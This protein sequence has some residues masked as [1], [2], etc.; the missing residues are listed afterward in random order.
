MI[1]CIFKFTKET[2]VC[3]IIQ[4]NLELY[5]CIFD[6]Y[7]VKTYFVSKDILQGWSDSWWIIS[8]LRTTKQTLQR[9]PGQESIVGIFPSRREDTEMESRWCD[10][11][12]YIQLV[13]RQGSSTIF[14]LPRDPRRPEEPQCSLHHQGHSVRAFHFVFWIGP[15]VGGGRDFSKKYLGSLV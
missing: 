3:H 8:K 9:R 4:F 12:R 13:G 7:C 10:E 11:D 5:A 2:E 14:R 15:G 6:K 1:V